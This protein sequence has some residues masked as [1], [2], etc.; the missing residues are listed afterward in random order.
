MEKDKEDFDNLPKPKPKRRKRT[1]KGT[2]LYID[3]NEMMVELIKYR[4]TGVIS[5]ILGAMFLKLAT[6]YT[7]R[8]N[9]A[10]YSYRD[11]FISAAVYR[12][13]EQVGKFDVDHPSQNPFAY[14]TQMAHNQILSILNKEKRQR[15]MQQR[16]RAK[17]WDNLCEQ[18]GLMKR[19]L[20]DDEENS[21]N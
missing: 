12:M 17:V 8:P 2:A 11:E 15:T 13:V 7:S 5:E 4:D 9:F 19:V 21:F 20:P 18:E 3:K 1:K 10:G 14:F 16:L 6:R